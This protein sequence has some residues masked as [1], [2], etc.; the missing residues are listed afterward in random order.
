MFDCLVLPQGFSFCPRQITWSSSNGFVKKRVRTIPSSKAVRF[1]QL[2]TVASVVASATFHTSTSSAAR[3]PQ[4]TGINTEQTTVHLLLLFHCRHRKV[5]VFQPGKNAQILVQGLVF[6]IPLVQNVVLCYL[7]AH[8]L[9]QKY[10]CCRFLAAQPAQKIATLGHW[11]APLLQ[12]PH[13]TKRGF[14]QKRYPHERPG[15]AVQA[16]QMQLG[17]G[18]NYS[19]WK[20][21]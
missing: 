19:Y 21:C 16:K 1:S 12:W 17:A 20:Y 6:K 10:S 15:R 11:E 3:L 7:K 5:N 14:L 8:H 13:Q 2:C 4:P 18:E 9:Q